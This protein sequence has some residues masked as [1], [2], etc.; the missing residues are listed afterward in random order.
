MEHLAPRAY[1]DIVYALSK[2][3]ETINM[4]APLYH[5]SDFI[6]FYFKDINQSYTQETIENRVKTLVFKNQ[7][8]VGHFIEGPK[9]ELTS[10]KIFNLFLDFTECY[11]LKNETSTL[12]KEEHF[13]YTKQLFD[14][15]P[16]RAQQEIVM[17]YN[18]LVGPD[19]K[20]EIADIDL[21]L[22]TSE[23]E[24]V[25]KEFRNEII[26]GKGDVDLRS[27]MTPLDLSESAL[28]PKNKRLRSSE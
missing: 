10:N 9:P 14:L 19:R 26:L 6:N 25:I 16:I 24:H 17:K 21:A 27:F 8:L 1:K 15:I 22:D 20:I 3:E 5:Y 7:S 11:M 28:A 18:G 23:M 4:I 13:V 12:S 2:D